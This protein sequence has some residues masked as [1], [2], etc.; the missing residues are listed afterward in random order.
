MCTSAMFCQE[1][2]FTFVAPSKTRRP[3][4]EERIDIEDEDIMNVMNDQHLMHRR[5]FA[6][7][8]IFGGD[9]VI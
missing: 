4:Q 1:S 6:E 3:D 2:I 5:K 9:D 8:L 7:E